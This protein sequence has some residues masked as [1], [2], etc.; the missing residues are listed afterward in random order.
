MKRRWPSPAALATGVVLLVTATATRAL[1]GQALAQGGSDSERARMRENG[2]RVPTCDPIAQRQLEA[3]LQALEGGQGAEALRIL[4]PFLK[5]SG[6]RPQ[7]LWGQRETRD[8]FVLLDTLLAEAK[9]ETRT[10]FAATLEADAARQLSDCRALRHG[11]SARLE[12]LLRAYPGT[13]AAKEAR[14]LLVDAA[15]ERGDELAARFYLSTCEAAIQAPRLEVLAAL[16]SMSPQLPWPHVQGHVDGTAATGAA[17]RGG[18]RAG[19]TNATRPRLLGTWSRQAM[20]FATADSAG[21]VG[22]LAAGPACAVF[23]DRSQLLVAVDFAGAPRF[24]HVDLGAVTGRLSDPPRRPAPSILGSRVFLVHGGAVATARGVGGVVEDADLFAFDIGRDATKLAW[25]ASAASACGPESSFLPVTCADFGHVFALVETRDDR[26]NRRVSAVA[27]TLQGDLLWKR[28]VA[29]GTTLTAD[30]L[31]HRQEAVRAG[32]L[33]AAAPVLADGR[34]CVETGLGVTACLDARDGT[35]LWSCKTARVSKL[36]GREAA[37]DE[38]R[39]LVHGADAAREVLVT[40]SDGVH[41]YRLQLAPGSRAIL[42]AEPEARGERSSLVG[43][44]DTRRSTYWWKEKLL[45]Q[46]PRRVKLD[47]GGADPDRVYDAPPLDR[48]DAL[49]AAP[50]LTKTSLVF[51]SRSMLAWLDLEKDLYYEHVL[52]LGA[53]GRAGFGPIVPWRDGVLFACDL[54]PLYWAP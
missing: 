43:L 28:E 11:R 33:T 47:V 52:D 42:A 21:V 2:S 29:R 49:A 1:H 44:V 45:E 9:P 34:L 50:L 10:S 32:R 35:M 30:L 41:A 53:L 16:A 36:R 27:Y 40:P 25:R 7:V 38:G 3:G 46:G 14:H 51:A 4:L 15:L 23:Q 13:S 20:G 22:K 5:P 18:P 24:E 17:T 37:W 6:P 26:L 48:G 54:G 8:F 39:L 12:A 31:M 19:P